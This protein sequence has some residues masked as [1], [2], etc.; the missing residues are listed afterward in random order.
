[1]WSHNDAGLRLDRVDLD[2][3]RH[4]GDAVRRL[5]TNL[6][7]EALL[8]P[9]EQS[10]DLLRQIVRFVTPVGGNVRH[11]VASLC[12]TID[13]AADGRHTVGVKIDDTRFGNATAY[14]TV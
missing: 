14:L 6:D 5:L 1:L 11:A 10:V 3:Y 12:S 9:I 13:A 2:G 7:G 4:A 8:N